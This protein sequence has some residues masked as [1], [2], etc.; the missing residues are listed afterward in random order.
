MHG[1][2]NR[3]AALITGL[4]MFVTLH[5]QKMVNSPYSRFSLGMIEQSVNFRSAGMGGVSV[6]SRDNTSVAWSNPASYSSLDSNSFVFD[7]GLDYTGAVL[8][9]ETLRHFS[10]DLNFDHLVLAFPLS[11]KWGV[12]AG[13]L[14][15]SNGYYYISKLVEVG[16]P[17]YDPIAGEYS[18]NHKGAGGIT[19]AFI[20]TG[21]EILP[22]LSA[23]INMN[24]LFGKIYRI[25]EYYFESDL[26]LFSSRLEE[27]LSVNGI[28]FETGL[29]YNIKINEKSTLTPAVAYTFGTKYRS[30]YANINLRYANYTLDPYSP[31]TISST[32]VRNGEVFIPR[33][34]SA[35][36]GY[37]VLNKITAAVEY[38][39]TNWNEASVYGSDG[40][41]ASTSSFRA[42]VEF[43]PD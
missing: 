10:S 41:M 15:Y 2:I 43:I 37:N 25:N 35:G 26:S 36:L 6:A 12:A 8:K 30:D 38:V 1:K 5:G 42:G 40:I 39:N 16:D 9:D 14:P 7:F 31:D 34:I 11:K 21:A 29:Q 19:R 33:T 22:N 20:G 23:G 28:S 32:D 17:E 24:I 4:A 13:I 3:I 18:I 27:N